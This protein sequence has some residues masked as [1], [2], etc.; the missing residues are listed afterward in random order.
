[1]A[2]SA[3]A[4]GPLLSRDIVC[5]ADTLGH[6]LFSLQNRI[7]SCEFALSANREHIRSVFDE[8]LAILEASELVVFDLLFVGWLLVQSDLDAL[9]QFWRDTQL[10]DPRSNALSGQIQDLLFR[11]RRAHG[12]LLRLSA[13]L[14]NADF[15]ACPRKPLEVKEKCKLF[16]ERLTLPLLEFAPLPSFEAGGPAPGEALQAVSVSQE[17]V[18]AM[19]AR[20]GDREDEGRSAEMRGVFG[21]LLFRLKQS[22]VLRG[23]SAA[24]KKRGLAPRALFSSPFY[25]EA[26]SGFS[27]LNDAGLA[28]SI[29]SFPL[30]SY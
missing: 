23:K 2:H 8:C 16:D 11:I 26:L 30:A 21:A 25:R 24:A 3:V 6:Q 20:L 27:L 15:G 9:Y 10:L 4:V 17:F 22:R 7:R 19:N 12:M 28:L 29:Q 5:D 1:M 14:S 13:E 18:A